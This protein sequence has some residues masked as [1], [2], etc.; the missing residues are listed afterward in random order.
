VDLGEHDRRSV[1]RAVPKPV[2]KLLNLGWVLAGGAIRSVVAGDPVRDWDIYDI[3]GTRGGD[4]AVSFADWRRTQTK[5]TTTCTRDGVVV[6]CIPRDDLE[7]EGT[8]RVFELLDGFDFT[9]CQAAV[10][11]YRGVCNHR[12]Y[13][14]LAARRIAFNE[15]AT[16]SLVDSFRRAM[17]FSERGFRMDKASLCT[18][19]STL[20]GQDADAIAREMCG[21]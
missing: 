10:F 2:L 20:T 12:F 4:V 21:Y 18:M 16:G 8:M 7:M 15:D 9:I 5:N 17:R 14:D 11:K 3:L 13:P 19:L 1:Y 6:Q